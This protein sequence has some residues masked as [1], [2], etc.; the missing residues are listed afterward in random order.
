MAHAQFET[1]HPFTDGNGRTGRALIHTVLRRAGA[2][3]HILILTSTVFASHTDSYV[4][5][6]TALRADPPSLDRWVISFAEAT[7]IA[8]LNGR[9]LAEN[10]RSLDTQT[11]NEL[12]QWRQEQGLNPV[13]PRQ[14]AVI[15]K[16]LGI[17][18]S[19]PV[20]TAESVNT[21]LH[22]SPATAHRTLVQL[23]E[24]GILGRTKDQRGR[25]ICWTADK[26]LE[27]IAFAEQQNHNPHKASNTVKS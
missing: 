19:S 27:L 13:K 2:V 12:V 26:Y 22:V 4:A 16:I 15:L 5:G 6:L 20:L 9:K 8:A 21:R 1:I 24:A 23:A 3:R 10:I 11:Q 18:A 7:E 14:D 25:L 17:L